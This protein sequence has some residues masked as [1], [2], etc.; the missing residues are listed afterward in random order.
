MLHGGSGTGDENLKR[1]IA[2]GIQKINLF[3]DMADPAGEAMVAYLKGTETDDP[4]I[5]AA[6]Q[7]YAGKKKNFLMAPMVGGDV[8]QAKL[9]HYIRLFGSAGKA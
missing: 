9:E 1:C 8:Y 4:D 7:K 3:T 6:V 5:Q 2:C